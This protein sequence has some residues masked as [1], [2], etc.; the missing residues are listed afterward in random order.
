MSDFLGAVVLIGLLALSVWWIRKTL[1]SGAW[2]YRG[3]VAY[4][5]KNPKLYR[6][7]VTLACAYPAFLVCVLLTMAN[8]KIFC[9]AKVA[10]GPCLVRTFQAFVR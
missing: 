8:Q 4:R 1:R 9:D 7:I 3:G 6:G 10:P 2:P 5:E